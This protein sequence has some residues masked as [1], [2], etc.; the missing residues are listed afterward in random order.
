MTLT[1]APNGDQRLAA[2]RSLGILDTDREKDFDDVVDLAATICEAPVALI[3]LVEEDRQWF[4]AERGFGKRE[5]PIDQSICFH[6]VT[7]DDYLEIEDTL[8]DPRSADNPLCCGG[9][10]MRFYAGAALKT[11]DGH[12]LGALCVLDRAPR[13]LSP[14]Q[15]RALQVLAGLVMKQIELMRARETERMLRKEVDHRVKNSLQAVASLTR[16]KA[17]RAET[18]EA[19]AALA[20][21]QRRIETVSALHGELYRTGHGERIDLAPYVAN[22]ARYLDGSRP[23]NVRVDV[24]VEAVELT[25]DQ[26]SAIGVV[27]N[28]CAT[29]SFKYAFPEGREGTFSIRGAFDAERRYRLTLADDGVGMPVDQGG[30]KGDGLGVRIMEAAAR[31]IGAELTFGLGGPGRKVEIVLPMMDRR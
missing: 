16:L 30:G 7:G 3:S 18:E 25:S 4:K 15:R 26:L 13:R 29:N 24:A 10:E 14:D 5:T 20:D 28:E 19:R 9:P 1:P 11:S 21:V 22:I 31:Q 23:P 8:L 12:K 17:A 6:V 2:L 27:L